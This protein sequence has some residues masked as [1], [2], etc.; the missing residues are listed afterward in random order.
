VWLAVVFGSVL[1]GVV[2]FERGDTWGRCFALAKGAWWGLL[3][4]LVVIALIGG[5]VGGVTGGVSSLLVSGDAAGLELVSSMI[6]T[7]LTIPIEMLGAAVA[8]VTYAE[9]RGATQA[10]TTAD[11]VRDVR[12]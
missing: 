4:R 8:V 10:T 9:R 5:V 2:A 3:G 11:L 6:N 7:V 12:R 1:T